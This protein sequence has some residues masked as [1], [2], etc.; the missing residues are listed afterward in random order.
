MPSG[1]ITSLSYSYDKVEGRGELG[2]RR[3]LERSWEEEEKGA[4]KLRNS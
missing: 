4:G 2:G 3:E 1:E